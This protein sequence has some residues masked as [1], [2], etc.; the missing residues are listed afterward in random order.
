M[1]EATN[2]GNQKSLD[3]LRDGDATGVADRAQGP[4]HI[5]VQLRA[6]VLALE[7]HRSAPHAGRPTGVL[8]GIESQLSVR[9]ALDA[10]GGERGD[11]L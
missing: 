5:G 2:L 8:V 7:R 11:E 4:V 3:E 6:Y 1:D 10:R 9:D